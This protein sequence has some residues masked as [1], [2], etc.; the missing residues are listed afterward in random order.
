MGKKIIVFLLTAVLLTGCHQRQAAEAFPV[1]T[2][3][4]VVREG[5]SQPV[6][7]TDEAEMR[8]ILNAL[9]LLGHRFKPQTDP[10]AL[11]AP[12]WSI[13]LRRS[14]GSSQLY[15][16]K[17]DLYIQEGRGPWRQTD[18][19]RLTALTALLRAHPSL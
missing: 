14:D 3:V 2:S 4:T 15:R 12:V 10:E 7:Y 16:V 19:D 5:R 17:G 11:N 1:V 8:P 13:T 6:Q 18:P 9:R